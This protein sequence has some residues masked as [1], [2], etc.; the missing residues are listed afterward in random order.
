MALVSLSRGALRPSV[1][2][3]ALLQGLKTAFIAFR[4][5]RSAE[6]RPLAAGEASAY[7][8]RSAFTRFRHLRGWGAQACE[9]RWI[10]LDRWFRSRLRRRQG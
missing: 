1:A 8:A 5:S 10:L 4:A 9:T 2:I 3:V 6:I 7:A